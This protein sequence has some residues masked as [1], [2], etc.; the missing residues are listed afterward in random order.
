MDVPT[1]SSTIRQLQTH[2]CKLDACYHIQN[3]AVR[4][5]KYS[6]MAFIF[7]KREPV[8]IILKYVLFKISNWVSHHIII[9]IKTFVKDVI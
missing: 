6:G 7:I 8:G 1:V 9:R 5:S 3:L 2:G 4:A